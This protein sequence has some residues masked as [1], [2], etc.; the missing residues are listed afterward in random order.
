M[1]ERY[2]GFRVRAK[3]RFPEQLIIFLEQ[4][5]TNVVVQIWLTILKNINA[6]CSI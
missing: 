6:V 2:K 1:R 5:Y 3:W 4:P